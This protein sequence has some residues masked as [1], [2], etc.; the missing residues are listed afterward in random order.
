M[1]QAAAE[2]DFERAARIRDELAGL[3]NGG[4]GGRWAVAG[5]R[6]VGVVA[7]AGAS[8]LPAAAESPAPSRH[9]R[10]R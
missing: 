8:G 6:P 7:V 10:R 9:D 2:L 4:G 5:R 1:M 3:R